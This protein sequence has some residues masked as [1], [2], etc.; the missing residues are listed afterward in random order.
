MLENLSFTGIKGS[1]KFND[2]KAKK[3]LN[4][5]LDH[6]YVYVCNHNE[7]SMD[8]EFLALDTFEALRPSMKFTNNIKALNPKSS[9]KVSKPTAED[10]EEKKVSPGENSSKPPIKPEEPNLE[11][12]EFEQ[13][14]KQ[15]ID[16]SFTKGKQKRPLMKIDYSQMKNVM[17]VLQN[18][19][20]IKKPASAEETKQDSQTKGKSSFGLVLTF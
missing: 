9:S 17:Q 4:K 6:F 14:L 11:E 16:K 10:E 19:Q 12:Q 1:G 8:L 13:E 2:K 15:M 18:S 20:Q 3:T 7:I 5:F